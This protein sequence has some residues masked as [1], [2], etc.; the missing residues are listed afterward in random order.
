MTIKKGFLYILMIGFV[1]SC[2]NN[3]QKAET[4]ENIVINEPKK[5]EKSFK[6]LMFDDKYDLV[7][8][9]PLSAGISDTTSYK[10]KLYGFCSIECK[11]AFVKEPDSYLTVKK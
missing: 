6:D 2:N 7:C 10:G 5:E 3:S 1:V 11:E 9:M 8:G 4:K